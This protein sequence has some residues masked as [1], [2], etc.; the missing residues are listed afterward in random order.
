MSL[1]SF[2]NYKAKRRRNILKILSISLCIGLCC[3]TF[4]SPYF[5]SSSPLVFC[6]H[7]WGKKSA[8][9]WDNR[10]NKTGETVH[11]NYLWIDTRCKG[12]GRG[13][14]WEHHRQ[15]ECN[16]FKNVCWLCFL[17]SHFLEFL[18]IYG[19]DFKSDY[20]FGKPIK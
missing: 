11:L 10:R 16:H 7:M 15:W 17:K 2:M 8:W 14:F 6:W 4:P 20:R 1:S 9:I 13:R 5:P 12:N 18:G 19:S 3:P